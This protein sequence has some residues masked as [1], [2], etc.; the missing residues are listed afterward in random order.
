[1][2]LGLISMTKLGLVLSLKPYAE[3]KHAYLDLFNELC[4]WVSVYTLLTFSD[5][6][7]IE[8]RL[9]YGIFL[10]GLTSFQLL[11]GLLVV[12]RAIVSDFFNLIKRWCFKHRKP[13]IRER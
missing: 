1:L 7:P 6:V 11:V 10:A 9:Y 2:M 3:S 4:I 5:A 8:S 12:V 13:P